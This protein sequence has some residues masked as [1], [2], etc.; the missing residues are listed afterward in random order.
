MSGDDRNQPER[1]PV[2]LFAFANDDRP[3]RRL[4]RL[5]REIEE[6]RRALAQ[7]ERDGTCELVVRESTT[8]EELI[9]ALEDP[10]Y[11]RRLTV[12][13]FAGHADDTRLFLEG[14]A[15]PIGARI[16]GL[17]PL[18]G[19]LDGLA[20]VFLNG[21]ATLAQGKR[22]AQHG[23]PAVIGTEHIV[24]DEH[25]QRFAVD[26]YRGIAT[27]ASIAEAFARAQAQARCFGPVTRAP[28]DLEPPADDAEEAMPWRLVL[29]DPD[30]DAR[31]WNLAFAAKDP[32]LGLPAP[33]GGVLP[34]EPY[35]GLRRFTAQESAVFFG[36]GRAIR[37]LYSDVTDPKLPPLVVVYGASGVG[38]SSLLEAGLLPRL[39]ATHVVCDVRLERGEDP[40]AL[41]RRALGCRDDAAAADAWRACED[42][43]RK[44]V[45]VCIDQLE[46]ALVDDGS[47]KVLARLV[48]VLATLAGPERPRGKLLLGLRKEWFPE[49]R[50]ELKRQGVKWHDHFVEPLG[51]DDIEEVVLG[52]T[53][54]AS[55]RARYGITCDHDLAR[56]IA[57]DLSQDRRSAIAPMLQILL[58]RMWEHTE[59]RFASVD[60]RVRR[61]FTRETYDALRRDGLALSDFVDRQLDVLRGAFP[62]ELANGLVLDLLVRH[63]TSRGTAAACTYADLRAAY[64]HQWAVVEGILERCVSLY[65]LTAFTDAHGVH[66]GVRLA[67][68]TLAPIIQERHRGSKAPGQAAARLLDTR[69]RMSE[70]AGRS[71]LLDE[72]DLEQVEAA[73]TAMRRWTADEQALVDA[74]RRR[75]RQAVWLR[76]VRGTVIVSLVVGLAAAWMVPTQRDGVTRLDVAPD[77]ATLP[78]LGPPQASA[79]PPAPSPSPDGFDGPDVT[80]DL[81]AR[82]ACKRETIGLAGDAIAAIGA[83]AASPDGRHVAVG[84]EGRQQVFVVDALSPIKPEPI[85]TVGGVRQLVSSHDASRLAIGQTGGNAQLVSWSS[86]AAVPQPCRGHEKVIN[87]AAFSADD[88]HLVTADH[89]GRVILRDGATCEPIGT[90]ELGGAVHALREQAREAWL[91][92]GSD[93]RLVRW[94]WP[95]RS[96]KVVASGGQSL[97]AIELLGEDGSVVSVG[98][99]LRAWDGSGRPGFDVKL[100]PASRW[101]FVGEGGALVV[102]ASKRDVRLWQLGPAGPKSLDGWASGEADI[103][104][105]AVYPDLLDLLVVTSDGLVHWLS[106]DAGRLEESLSLQWGLTEGGHIV[107]DPREQYVAV[108]D[109]AG[110]L[111]VARLPRDRARARKCLLNDVR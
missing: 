109:R 32:L 52:P 36:R 6:I 79:D 59:P 77:P 61:R 46:R 103:T 110:R 58:T 43:R 42:V 49:L 74:S 81:A 34:Q 54:S 22:L 18:L 75:R 1:R 107:L 50:N 73:Q 90:F 38:K 21:C 41:L 78:D 97:N 14:D 56:R 64:E 48:R 40:E 29:A 10:R 44:P 47:G 4:G 53:R 71:S 2:L 62:R 11:R 66:L 93:G 45:L 87:A 30:G 72:H 9:E 99:R 28:R 55:L 39:V 51:R 76:R 83:I 23:I 65:V 82:E 8:R 96:P 100:S 89:A 19:E 84:M 57:D 86:A 3:G 12:I 7:A 67:H 94:H 98:Q 31:D 26:F 15:G 70:S 111:T 20:L 92:A 85:G 13:H 69:M 91:V 33:V 105:V 106:R 16:Q 88:A 63:T 35:M 104:D 60:G 95:S 68:D 5:G 37:N 101:V 80:P 24:D 17:A 25:A 27:G 102:S 108:G